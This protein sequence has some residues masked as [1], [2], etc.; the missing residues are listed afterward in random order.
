MTRSASS[1]RRGAAFASPAKAHAGFTLVELLVGMLIFAVA[2]LGLAAGSVSVIRANQT[3]HLRNSALTLAQAKLERLKAISASAFTGMSCPAYTSNGCSDSPIASG[4][5]F[6]RSW[7]I[8]VNSPVVG[9]NRID[10]KVDWSDYTDHSVVV[11]SS[12]PQ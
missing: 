9:V 5:T 2:L 12:V 8:A 7:Q 3:S 10:V 11:S 1:R 4:K 6:S